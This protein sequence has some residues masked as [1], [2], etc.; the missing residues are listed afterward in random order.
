MT[1]KNAQ[2]AI[3]ILTQY[4]R[5]ANKYGLRL[6]EQKIQELNVLRDNGLIRASN[7]PAKLRN[8]FPGEFS[9]MNLN[10]IRAY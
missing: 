4:E 5:L 9:E 10:E 1:A 6:S 8:E 7:L 3:K 2:K